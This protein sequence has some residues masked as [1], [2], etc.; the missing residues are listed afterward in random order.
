MKN[1]TEGFSL[2]D[3]ARLCAQHQPQ[4]VESF[5]SSDNSEA[6]LSGEAAAAGPAA[7]GHS[8]APFA[9]GI[10]LLLVTSC[11]FGASTI[12]DALAFGDAASEASHAFTGAR[13]EKISGGLGE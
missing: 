1:I 8:R 13:S 4:R 10:A 3:G 2:G 9:F 5:A 6:S 11:C 12:T 7:A